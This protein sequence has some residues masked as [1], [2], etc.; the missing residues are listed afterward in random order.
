M[1][2]TQTTVDLSVSD[3]GVAGLANDHPGVGCFRKLLRARVPVNRFS[4]R[5]VSFKH[6]LKPPDPKPAFY[7]AP[8]CFS[9]LFS[10][11]VVVTQHGTVGRDG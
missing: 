1:P 4:P 9:F 8:C 3:L 6:E 5:R 10:T 11:R 7:S 2:E